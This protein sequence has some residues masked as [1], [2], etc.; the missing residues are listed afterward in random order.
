MLVADTAH[1]ANAGFRLGLEDRH[2]A[3]ARR[4]RGE[5]TAHQEDAEPHQPPHGGLGPRPLP[6][7]PTRPVPPQEHVLAAGRR[8]GRSVTWRK[9]SKA[10][11]IS[12]SVLPRVRLAGRCP[13]P[14]ADGTIPSPG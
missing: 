2:L 11:T 3:C 4:A 8:A 9:A 13:K 14:A 7:Y 6:R 12:R 5:T 10:A 1:G